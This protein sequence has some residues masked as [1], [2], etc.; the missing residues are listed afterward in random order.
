MFGLWGLAVGNLEPH[1]N[2][3]V[4]KMFKFSENYR[5]ALY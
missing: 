3:N 5:N 2:E 4:K 1:S